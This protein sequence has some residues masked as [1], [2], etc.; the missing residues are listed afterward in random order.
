MRLSSPLAIGTGAAHTRSAAYTLPGVAWKRR[1]LSRAAPQPPTWARRSA[2]RAAKAS[3]VGA[4]T[5]N[6]AVDKAATTSGRCLASVHSVVNAS[7]SH[8]ISAEEIVAS[9]NHG[10]GVGKWKGRERT[11]VSSR[12][13][14]RR[15]RFTGKANSRLL[16]DSFTA[17]F[18]RYSCEGKGGR[19]HHFVEIKGHHREVFF[20]FVWGLF[21]F[22]FQDFVFYVFYASLVHLED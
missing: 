19:K 1:T 3:S 11:I 20:V 15:N 9:I 7:F 10:V 12:P 8:A 14:G 6:S 21:C 16:T 13:A 22:L 4:K 5:V 2:S 17:F 18:G